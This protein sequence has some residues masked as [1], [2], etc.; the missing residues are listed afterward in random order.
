MCYFRVGGTLSVDW[1]SE[2]SE[3]FSLLTDQVRRG[4]RGFLGVPGFARGPIRGFWNLIFL[5]APAVF[6]DIFDDRDIRG[7]YVQNLD[8]GGEDFE[9][10]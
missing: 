1:E 4:T 2:K 7:G 3:I 10:L 8:A 5:V 6:F 9:K